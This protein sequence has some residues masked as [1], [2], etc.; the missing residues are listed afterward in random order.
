MISLVRGKFVSPSGSAKNEDKFY[1][2]PQQYEYVKCLIHQDFSTSSLFLLH[3]GFRLSSTTFVSI[4]TQERT[5]GTKPHSNGTHS[6]YI[7][8]T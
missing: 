1:F 8:T 6:N 3:Q 2:S 4:T 5:Q 7:P